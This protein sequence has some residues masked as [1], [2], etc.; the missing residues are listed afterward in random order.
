M[1]VREGLRLSVAGVG[2]GLIVA[3]SLTRLVATLLVGVRATDSPTY[4]AMAVVF[5]AIAAV[6]SWLPA[7]RAA[8]LNPAIALRD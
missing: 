1:V 4:G 2:I 8:S 3:S 7:R 5:F 6:S